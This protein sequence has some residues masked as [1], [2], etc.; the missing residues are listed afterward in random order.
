M[1]YGKLP[2]NLGLHNVFCEEMLFYQYMPI[3]LLGSSDVKIEQRLSPFFD[4]VGVINCDF[5]GSFGLDRFIN[6]YIYLTAKRLY[7]VPGCSFNRG[8]WHS[9]GFMTDDI[10]YVWCDKSPTIFNTS[11]FDLSMDDAISM[12]EMER[13]AMPQKDVQYPENSLLMLDQYNIHKV[14]DSDGYSGMR[15]FLKISFSKDKYDLSGNAKNYLLDYKWEMRGRK[16]Q[17]NIP[18]TINEHK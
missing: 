13:Q 6:S 9:D 7:Q 4:L 8:G 12:V 16:P 2:K 11:Y 14:N 5:I 3:K 15:T 10:N 1:K 18:Q 17:R